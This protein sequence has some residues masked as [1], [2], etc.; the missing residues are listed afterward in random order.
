MS[1]IDRRSF[2]QV[3]I[4]GAANAAV[5]PVTAHRGPTLSQAPQTPDPTSVAL[6][7][8]DQRLEA[9][10]FARQLVFRS[11]VKLEGKW[12][13]ATLS[14][15]P[16][17]AG[18]S[19][20]LQPKLL[21]RSGL[22]IVSQGT[23]RAEGA[24]GQPVDYTWDAQISMPGPEGWFRV[25][26]A[27]KLPEPLRLKQELV[28]EPQIIVWLTSASTMMEGQSASW[29]RVLLDQPT[30]NSLDAY[31]NDL[32]SVYLLDATRGVETMLYF[33]LSDMAW[34]SLQNVPRFLA[35]RCS[36][37]SRLEKDGNQTLGIGLI[38]NQATG[39]TLPAGDI[40]FTYWLL[41]RPLHELLNE[42]QAVTRWMEALLPLFEERLDWPQCATSWKKFAAGTVN[43]VQQK[44][45]ALISVNGHRGLRAYVK[46]S[47]E[48]WHET[49]S[50][51]EL[52]T[53]ADVLWP[54]LLYL[55]V[56]PNPGYQ[57]VVR[58]LVQSMPLFYHEDTRSISNDFIRGENEVADSWYPFENSLIKYPLI[59]V[60][61]G[62]P[63]LVSNFLLAYETATKMAHRY[64]HLFPI[65]YR[66]DSL[67][68]RG[69]GTNYA[70]G[71]LYAWA[72]LI[73]HRLTGDTRY[74]DEARRALD[75]LTTVRAAGL[76]HEPQE[77]AFGALAA[78]DLG[79]QDA[80]RYL[81]YEQL[82][83][84]YWYSDPSQKTHDI[85]GMVQ[86]AASI[87]YPAFKENVEA[88]LPW[89]GIMKRGVMVDALLRFMDQQRRNNFY[90][91]DSCHGVAGKQSLLPFIPYENLGT[92]ELGGQT[93]VVGK[94]IYGS[95]EVLWSYLMFE[96]LGTTDDRELM[97]VNLDLLDAFDSAVF[98]PRELNFILF[99]PTGSTRF[100]RVTIPAAGGSPVTLNIDGGPASGPIPLAPRKYVRI[101]AEY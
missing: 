34:M 29:R 47:S 92:L 58:D 67:E 22:T 55:Q 71:G 13:A 53:M 69:A 86:A 74:Q 95:G 31:G 37:V 7:S 98:P 1:K 93:G 44:D 90:Y 2:V 16:L 57:Q 76:F 62:S 5:L 28:V 3:L 30:R 56:Q 9:A 84:F 77:L 49:G 89:T 51:F 64:G 46:A 79:M 6:E 32:P 91:F 48:L 75:M 27:L 50:N 10:T 70:V 4:A 20:G 63:A 101:K 36:T 19:F 21:E 12:V 41:Q 68:Q 24:R 42:R 11:F 18:P 23:A 80:A 88:I 60:L 35:Y 72:G 81:L 38:A 54:S 66:T 14:D 8:A 87:L 94:E 59:G 39:N 78:A 61:S 25:R 83:M 96:A 17:V 43:D 33:D 15:V 73:A 99:N 40:R 97:L 26:V 45:T 65:Y 100:A 52:M 85:R 82:R